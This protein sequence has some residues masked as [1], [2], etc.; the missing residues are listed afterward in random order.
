[1]GGHPRMRGEH[2]LLG[3]TYRCDQG[4]SPHARGALCVDSFDGFG[5]G[6][7]PAC[8]GSTGASHSPFWIWRGHPRMRG[9]HYRPGRLMND[10]EGSSPHARGA[11]F[12]N[13]EKD[14]WVGVIPACAGSTIRT[15]KGAER[16]RGHPRM[17]GE[18]CRERHT[19][20]N[21]AGSS[22]HARVALGANV[23]RVHYEGVIPA[24]AGSTIPSR[25]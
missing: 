1:M 9:E 21:C 17:R 25:Q 7:I 14:G 10:Y 20:S 22:P 8:A 4:S 6:V 23:V 5:G 19:R 18:H 12:V 2:S 3:F 15:S 11:R 24:C 16:G 13:F